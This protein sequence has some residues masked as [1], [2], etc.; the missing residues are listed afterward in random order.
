MRISDWS[1]DVCSSDLS[2]TIKAGYVESDNDYT[3]DTRYT[4]ADSALYRSIAIGDSG[5][6]FD[7]FTGAGWTGTRSIAA[8]DTTR[9]LPAINNRPDSASSM[10]L[11]GGHDHGT[12]TAD[13]RRPSHLDRPTANHP[14]P[15]HTYPHR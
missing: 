5:A 4:G 9:I 3:E 10:G 2:H 15:A 13:G 7:E 11:L 6:T 12:T 8:G 14:G 1:S